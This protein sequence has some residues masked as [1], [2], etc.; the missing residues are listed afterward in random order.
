MTKLLSTWLTDMERRTAPISAWS[1]CDETSAS[2]VIRLNLGCVS[3]LEAA[4]GS[5]N[6]RASG[7]YCSFRP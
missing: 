5:R 6:R 3:S 2:E 7:S 1:A 4:C